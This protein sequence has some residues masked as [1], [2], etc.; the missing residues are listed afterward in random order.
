[1]AKVTKKL[2]D[3]NGA[4]LN[5]DNGQNR[6][7]DWNDAWGDSSKPDK[8]LIDAVKESNFLMNINT[9]AFT[10]ETYPLKMMNVSL[11]LQSLRNPAGTGFTYGNSK[12]GGFNDNGTASTNH[13]TENVLVK[14]NQKVLQPYPYGAVSIIPED[15]L[16]DNIEKDNFL[17]SLSNQMAPIISNRAAQSALYSSKGQTG[18][19]DGYIYQD[20]ILQQLSDIANE[21]NF[22]GLI[23]TAINPGNTD[24]IQQLKTLKLRLL[25]Q[26][27]GLNIPM[28]GNLKYYIDP[29]FAEVL[30][31]MVSRR[32][33]ELGDSYFVN[34]KGQLMLGGTPV[35]ECDELGLPIGKW[36]TYTPSGGTATPV[37]GYAM[38]S[39]D[40]NLVVGF[41]KQVTVNIS[42]RM[43]EYFS[44]SGVGRVKFDEA[45]VFDHWTIAA[46][47]L[48]VDGFPV[49]N[50][51]VGAGLDV[52]VNSAPV[53]I[54]EEFK[55]QGT[56][57][58]DDTEDE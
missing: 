19:P 53:N 45:V 30:K 7:G 57:D 42:K 50:D 35:V 25:K 56:E 12:T 48:P 10:S 23:N 49:I 16:E 28:S 37:G 33:T 47:V 24:S 43:D 51:G 46:P 26:I 58:V 13:I 31:E 41:R 1:M 54:F 8:F 39:I 44:Y 2:I 21:G 34:D 55:N 3:T 36:S 5:F 18:L 11:E 14:F 4:I 29:V 27:R 17:N 15:F 22:A 40:S 6:A 9:P 20:G 32:G 52:D 38:I